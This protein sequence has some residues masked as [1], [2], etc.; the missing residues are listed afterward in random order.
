MTTRIFRQ[1]EIVV[2][3]P[4]WQDPGDENI[5]FIVIDDEKKK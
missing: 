4:E 2:F 5:L 1:N 3:K